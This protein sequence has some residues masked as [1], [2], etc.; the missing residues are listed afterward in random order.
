MDVPTSVLG[1]AADSLALAVIASSN[2]PVLLLDGALGVVAASD[3]FC[4]VFGIDPGRVA[5]RPLS[6][7][8]EGEWNVPQL[9]SLL[10]ATAAGA[11]NIDAYEMDLKR[12]G[13]VSRRLVVN[14]RKLDYFDA[15]NVRLVASMADVT[16][17][18]ISEKLKDDLLREKAILLQELQH[19]VANS[20]QIIASVL[21][22]S[23]RRVRS[24][25]ARG[26]LRDARNRVMSIATMQRQLAASRLGDVAL[27]T[28]F[29]DLCDSIGASMISDHDQLSL[30]VAVDGSVAKAEI[31]VSLG[32]IV[33]EL[34]INALKHAF[35]RHR[36][37]K[38]FVDYRSDGPAWTLSVRDT[39]VGMPKDSGRP[40][41]GT[42][43][44][45]AL[46]GQLDASVEVAAANPGTM[47]SIVHA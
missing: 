46:A 16:D 43:I 9:G 34:V 5:G 27:R 45:E 7:L 19:R 20:L 13:K 30:E 23:A 11:A 6:A 3:S 40:G 38:I 14:A 1:E 4:D 32:L 33:T 22:Q 29:T 41:L 25:K 26:Q 42:G 28:Y 47:V 18:R 2:A 15:D 10:R 35:P 21:M 8:G 17:A 36:K 39:G 12:P 31:S 24:E 37:G 44:V